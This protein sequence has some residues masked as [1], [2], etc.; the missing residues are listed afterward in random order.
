MCCQFSSGLAWIQFN[1]GLQHLVIEDLRPTSMF[2]VLQAFIAV[3]ET[4]IERRFCVPRRL[5]GKELP[6]VLN[7]GQVSTD[8]T[9]IL[10][11]SDFPLRNRIRR[12]DGFNASVVYNYEQH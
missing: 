12:D 3:F 6:V 4:L 10:E 8:A 5:E 11:S 7:G 9:S 1:D 2:F